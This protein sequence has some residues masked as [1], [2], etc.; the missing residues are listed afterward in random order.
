VAK[1]NK[2]SPQSDSQKKQ[3]NIVKHSGF[4]AL[5]EVEILF[6]RLFGG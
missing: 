2:V 6:I 5:I 4:L 1:K 3:N